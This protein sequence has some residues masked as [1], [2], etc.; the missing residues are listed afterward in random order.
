[1]LWEL[2]SGVAEGRKGN[3]P[4]VNINAALRHLL[5]GFDISILHHAL[6]DILKSVVNE[7]FGKL[8]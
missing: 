5:R 6:L 7:H 8:S 3:C 2:F 4:I 1:M